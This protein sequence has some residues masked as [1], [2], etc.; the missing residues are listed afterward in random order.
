MQ[1]I[2]LQTVQIKKNTE[3]PYRILLLSEEINLETIQFKIRP[4][5]SIPKKIYESCKLDRNEFLQARPFCD[6]A[7]D[8]IEVFQN[9]KLVFFNSPQFYLLKSQF[10]KIGYIFNV[11]PIYITNPKTAE[12]FIKS[13]PITLKI[14][15]NGIHGLEFGTILLNAMRDFFL[16]NSK[17]KERAV[18]SVSENAVFNSSQYKGTAGVYYFFDVDDSVIYVGKAK[19]LKKRLQSHFSNAEKNSNIDYDA[20][21]KITVEYTGND[22]IAQLLE[23]FEIKNLQPIYNSQQ[24]KDAAP[25]IINYGKTAAGICKL[26]IVRKDVKDNFPEKHFN[27]TSVKKS[28]LKFCS[29]Y[30]LCKKYC[31]IER[32]KGPCSDYY[33]NKC[34]GI[35]AGEEPIDSYNERF[36]KALIEFLN[37]KSRKIYKLKGRTS[38]EDSFIY[39]VNDIYE[40]YGFINKEESIYS[41]N[42]ILGHLIPQKNNYDT[43][44]IIG[45]LPKKVAT[46][47]VLTLID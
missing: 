21:A 44:R 46:E 4:E 38:N 3:I 37:I 8:L 18:K 47:N 11:K 45:D 29:T 14:S 1:F 15:K 43:S 26:Q 33:L 13:L 24:R 30:G 39:T 20:I 41:T 23:S 10:R 12:D 25:F 2:Y 6:I 36:E 32:V 28:L 9:E 7:D 40:G 42:D 27:R 35:C 16:G 19:N 5:I 31:G 17:L 22:I 34:N